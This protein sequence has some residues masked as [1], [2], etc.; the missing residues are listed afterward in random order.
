MN[1]SNIHTLNFI[2]VLVKE[3][4][5]RFTHSEENRGRIPVPCGTCT[6]NIAQWIRYFNTSNIAFPSDRPNEHSLCGQTSSSLIWRWHT[7]QVLLISWEISG[8]L[9]RT[10]AL[11]TWLRTTRLHNSTQVKIY[12]QLKCIFS[13]D[14]FSY[15]VSLQPIFYRVWASML[16]FLNSK[17]TS[18]R[19][20]SGKMVLRQIY[21]LDL[22]H[23]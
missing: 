3:T 21:S 20:R 4:Q 17:Q 23:W 11:W 5:L 19:E 16:V 22:S 15:A 9:T 10:S 2:S 1:N 7:R 13:F 14:S 12:H 8:H 18:L 6:D